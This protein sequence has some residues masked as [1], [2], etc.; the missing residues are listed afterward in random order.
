MV[1][2]LNAES[3]NK[4]GQLYTYTSYQELLWKAIHTEKHGECH[5]WDTIHGCQSQQVVIMVASIVFDRGG[6]TIP[7]VS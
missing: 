1:D 5:T 3:T 4:E 2:S 6:E 7:K